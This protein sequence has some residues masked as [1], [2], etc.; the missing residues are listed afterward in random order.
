MAG[1]PEFIGRF[2]VIRAL[3]EGGMG[4][5]YLAQDP[6]LD[7]NL[8]IKLLKDDSPD[9]RGRF[10]REARTA[11]RLRHPNIVSIFD[12]DEFD[13]HPFI[14]ME[15]VPGETLAEII[16]RRAPLSLTRKLVIADELCRGLAHAHRQG[17]VH[18]D[19]KPAN[20]MIDSDETVKILDFGIARIGGSEMTKSGMLVGTLGY[21]SPEQVSASAIDQRSDI[22]SVGAVFYELLA[23][24]RAFSGSMSEVVGQILYKSP[25]P[26]ESIVPGLDSGVVAIVARALEKEAGA[27]YQDMGSMRRDVE[28]ARVRVES[29][30]VGNATV[31]LE[32]GQTEIRPRGPHSDSAA[33]AA[34]L[35]DEARSAI[36]RGDFD[37]ARSTIDEAVAL[38]ASNA[39]ARQLVA[40][41]DER[42]REALRR[43]RLDEA[44]RA[45]ADG[46]WTEAAELLAAM[47]AETPDDAEAQRL[48]A[49][50]N[51]R[52]AERNEAAARR[53]RVDAA[54]A[55]ARQRL[56]EGALDAARR[57]LDEVPDELDTSAVVRLRGDIEAALAARA[58]RERA[59]AEAERVRAAIAGGDVE[60][61]AAHLIALHEIA[62]ASELVRSLQAD[63]DRLKATIARRRRVAA[64]LGDALLALDARDADAAERAI[65]RVRDADPTTPALADLDAQ[66]SE[67]RREIDAE[68]QAAEARARAI[69]TAVADAERAL[70]DGQVSQARDAVERLGTLGSDEERAGDLTVRIDREE[71]RQLEQARLAR[72]RA[73][74]ERIARER[75]E[76]ERIA[77][78]RIERELAEQQRLARE[79]ADVARVAKEKADQARAEQERAEEERVSRERAERELAE[80]QR[81][82][83][84]RAE[85]ER[86]AKEKADQARAEQERADQ[87]RRVRA[88]AEAERAAKEKKEQEKAER[89]AKKR[90]DEERAA[91]KRAAEERADA[92]AAE[93]PTVVRPE[94]PTV[95]RVEPPATPD[96]APQTKIAAWVAAG[97]VAATLVAAVWYRSSSSN[98][99]PAPPPIVNRTLPVAPSPSPSPSP[100]VVAPS[101]APTPPPQTTATLVPV[102][103][104]SVPWTR[105][106]IRPASSGVTLQPIERT[107]PFTIDLPEG[108]YTFRLVS[109]QVTAAFT[110]QVRVAAGQSNRVL[111]TLP[112]YDPDRVLSTILGP[113]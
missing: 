1:L 47:L 66:L 39:T 52:I 55:R 50:V 58:L 15:Y 67:L 48:A 35:L 36:E 75:A 69:E 91:K 57:A 22:F 38:D 42:Q 80:Q 33:A 76:Q 13:G 44:A 23:Y 90:A 10:E 98:T 59:A 106:T 71:A 41:V 17:I 25:T 105:V 26:L 46:E 5:V 111:I 95:V 7:R 109:D 101:P 12:V 112:S 4:S 72:E 21:M 73:E 61:A 34:R 32:A 18:R 84:E 45:E 53:Q 6:K 96:R 11:A 51:A 40:L 83:R 113:R 77:R 92:A 68:R 110:Q 87:E 62:P 89:A 97:A 27:R 79:R 86:V 104:D 8:A 64:A 88:R 2:R 9:L 20:V 100:A 60:G 103:V 82:A 81:L 43:L 99:S 29:E 37:K 107:T 78:E 54:L 108:D 74:Q 70:A 102:S 31:V 14:A 19:I 16:K 94:E 28:R 30:D 85:A 93:A 65:E 63:L 56:A 24:R 3:G 49:A